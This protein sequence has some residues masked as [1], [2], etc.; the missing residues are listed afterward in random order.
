MGAVHLLDTMDSVDEE[1]IVQAEPKEDGGYASRQKA[2]LWIVYGSSVAAFTY[3]EQPQTVCSGSVLGKVP[4]PS[5]TDRACRGR[6]LRHPHL[7]RGLRSVL[8]LHVLALGSQAF[9]TFCLYY[10]TAMTLWRVQL[11]QLPAAIWTTLST[12]CPLLPMLAPHRTHSKIHGLVLY[13]H[14][15]GPRY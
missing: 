14:S 13:P 5:V 15:L 11:I 9:V 2:A 8:A 12:S 3:C 7:A 1:Q 4:E 10:K 6:A